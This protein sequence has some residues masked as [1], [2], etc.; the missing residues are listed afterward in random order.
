MFTVPSDGRLIPTSPRLFCTADE[1]KEHGRL[2]DGQPNHR[3]GK[4]TAKGR[5]GTWK[6][7]EGGKYRPAYGPYS[8][9]T[10]DNSQTTA[11]S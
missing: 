7:Y 8:L 6:Q 3:N 10:A 2:E 11:D 1:G 9:R 5:K 4:N